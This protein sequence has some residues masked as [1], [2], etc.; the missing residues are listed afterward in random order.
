M[1]RTVMVTSRQLIASLIHKDIDDEQADYLDKLINI[2]VFIYQNSLVQDDDKE[3][4]ALICENLS[5]FV[6]L[7]G[8]KF[9]NKEQLKEISFSLCQLI[10]RNGE[11]NKQIIEEEDHDMVLID[12]VAYTIDD[13]SIAYGKTFEPYF[14]PI[15]KEFL[16][17]FKEN[18]SPEDKIMAMGSFG[19]AAKAFGDMIVPYLEYMFPLV[20]KGIKSDENGIKRNALYCAGNLCMSA[21]E[22]MSS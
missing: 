1:R 19:V 4:V 17:Y 20:V 22:E 18:K 3:T 21:K 9:L 12:A 13:I 14:K 10:G 7:L 8:T 6:K 5:Y 11:C 16:K 15:F 2:C